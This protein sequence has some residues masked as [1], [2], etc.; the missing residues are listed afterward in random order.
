MDFIQKAYRRFLR[1]ESGTVVIEFV[2]ITP[3]LI[4]TIV[5]MYSFWDTF[6]VR[7]QFQKA[8]HTI[9]NVISRTKKGT[10]L[11]GDDISGYYR[12]MNYLISTD[13]EVSVRITEY[14]YFAA[15]KNAYEVQWS[16]R[17]GGSFPAGLGNGDLAAMRTTT[18][19]IMANGDTHI[20]L[21]TKMNYTSPFKVNFMFY[22]EGTTNDYVFHEIVSERPRDGDFTL[23]GC[24]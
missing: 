9:S 21:E 14:K 19:P 15:P 1:E 17:R 8:T 2:L 16:C 4:W 3:L 12:L 22:G 5:A 13:V 20:L 24:N 10:P 23:A 6:R 11:T 18:L 7:N